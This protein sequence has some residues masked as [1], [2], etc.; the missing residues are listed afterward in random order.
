MEFGAAT[1]RGI[2]RG[3]DGGEALVE[4][5]QGGCGRC[6]EEGGCGGQALTRMFC[7]GP[8]VYRVDNSV[9]AGIGDRVDIALKP[10]NL[11]HI[12]NRVYLVPLVA[13]IGGGVLGMAAGGEALSI[14]GFLLG[15]AA[16]LLVLRRR[17]GA[18]NPS[19][20]PYIISRKS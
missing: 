17:E 6:H 11:R 8:S 16:A 19:S 9:G 5:E 7:S 2:V 4:V 18:G 1:V 12:A 13:G 14:G 20:R 3:V 10:G 15:L